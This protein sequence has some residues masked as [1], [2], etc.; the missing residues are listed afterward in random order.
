MD[1]V[2]E[3]SARGVLAGRGV[4]RELAQFAATL[5]YKAL[6]AEA[7]AAARL[8]VLN[9]LAAALG[10]AQTR[11]GRLHTE[12][13]RGIGGGVQE[14][15]VIGN[16]ARVSQPVAAYANGS[17]AFALDYEDVCQYVIHA[18]PI[19]VPA[20]LAVGEAGCVSGRRLLAAVVAGYEV[21]TRIGWSMQPSPERGA[22]VWGQQYT[23]FAACVA[24][25]NLLG[26]DATAMDAAMGI[27]GAYAPVPSAYKYFGIVAETRPM[28][29]AKLGWGWMSMAGVMGALSARKGFRGGHGILDGQEGFWIMAG[30]DRC[31][32]P[33]MTRGLGREWLILGTDFKLHPSIA[34][35]HPPYVAL[36]K[37]MQANK[38]R[39]SD[40]LKL[41]VWNVGVARI[42]DF[43]PQSAVDAQFSLPY[44]MATT[45]LGE[46]LTPRLYAESKIA[47][48]PVQAMLKR[49]ECLSDPQ[50]DRDWFERNQMRSKVEL[51]LADGRVL[52]ESATF[53]GDKPQY[54]REQVI[55]KLRSMSDGL[56]PESRVA[57][58]V[59]TVDRLAQLSNV[60][61]L[62]RLL[63]PPRVKA[64]VRAKPALRRAK[65]Q[66]VAKASRRP[67]R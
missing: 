6:P 58:I 44:A 66:P 5:R 52:T 50:M 15:T 64:A 49:I 55:A 20:A 34:W 7:I 21:G 30:S 9:I 59:D 24:A 53:P 13:A 46:P 42:A 33:A 28:R 17:L 10:G 48:R 22:Q 1:E 29:E 63:V 40:V 61:D 31:D 35:S 47:S 38:V 25:G 51:Q 37:L 8:A 39:A 26:L 18:G 60:G 65:R 27:T 36:T 11:I 4:T 23:P 41:K 19:V 32:F 3:V 67:P 54:G 43:A 14:S 45:L 62:V 12:L 16:G 2:V 56:L 57:Q